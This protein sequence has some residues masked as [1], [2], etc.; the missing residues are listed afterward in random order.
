MTGLTGFDLGFD[1][2]V[3]ALT[4]LTALRQGFDRFD[5]HLTGFDRGPR[6]IKTEIDRK[7]TGI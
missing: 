5:K 2:S 7:L 3:T 1:S 4:A 6:R